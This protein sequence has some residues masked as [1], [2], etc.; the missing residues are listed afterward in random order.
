MREG[1]VE[2]M[3]E[4][5]EWQEVT[6]GEV[7]TIIGGA[8]PSTKKEEYYNGNIPW[9]TPKDLSNYCYRYIS[10][11]ERSITELGLSSC[12]AKLMPKNSI[13]FTSRA[14]IGYI[15]ISNNQI[16]TNQGFKSIVPNKDTDYMFLYYLL[17]YN[18]NNIISMGSGTTFQEISGS[19]MKNIEVKVPSL[20]EQKAIAKTL[21]CLDEKIE[22][23]RN[24]NK[25]LEE[26]AQA[27]FKSW[28]VDDTNN[29]TLTKI[30]EMPIIV[31]DYVANGSFAS[32]KKNV[33]LIQSPEYA[34]FIRNTDL[35]SNSFK[36]FVN[37][38]SYEFL[39]KT[40]LYG[41]EIIISNVGDVGS[42]FLCPKLDKPMSLGN[43][44][45]LIKST[46]KDDIY[47][48]F[49]YI[50]F[51]WS[52]GKNLISSITSGSA[53]LKFNKTDFKSLEIYLP[54]ETNIVKFNKNVSG[55][56]DIIE[57][58][59]QEIEKL[60]NIR[61]TLLPKLMSGEVRVPVWEVE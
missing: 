42:V 26:M 7:G 4:W 8:T 40:K 61:D 3:E 22:L 11:G 52:Y 46:M 36:V 12:S 56:F 6:L 50:L 47:K 37:Q 60:K 9:L 51:K 19:V 10:N 15:A 55:V 35:K 5:K 33:E 20:P 28:F 13:L 53:Q 43:N 48:Y 57:K 1:R 2:F 31:T 30:S 41:G 59:Q 34:Y 39:N 23:N 27:I 21:S 14:P 25:T 32:L 38:H 29:C 49:L 24:M 17:Q 16:C 58:N 18:K 54:N 44:I 45:V